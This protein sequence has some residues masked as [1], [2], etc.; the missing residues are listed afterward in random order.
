MGRSSFSAHGKGGGAGMAAAASAHGNVFVF[1]QRWRLRRRAARLEIA[2]AAW[3]L[4][5]RYGA[6]AHA[7]ARNSARQPVGIERRKFWLKV[8]KR[9]RGGKPER[10][11]MSQ[12]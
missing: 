5:E 9:L 4:R 6:A 7:I 11:L 1:W 10:Q 2:R 12:A 3:E 8:A